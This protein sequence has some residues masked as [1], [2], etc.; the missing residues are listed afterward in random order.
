[1]TT[2]HQALF[3]YNY[4]MIPDASAQKC[5]FARLAQ[6]HRIAL[7]RMQPYK[8]AYTYAVYNIY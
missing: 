8:S 1:M 4:G 3:I 7:N 2:K 6:C 5:A